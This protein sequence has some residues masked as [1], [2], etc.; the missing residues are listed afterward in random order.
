MNMDS[1]NSVS[2]LLRLK[3]QRWM[4]VLM[5]TITIKANVPHEDAH[6]LKERI[7]MDIERYGD[8]KVISVIS[9]R[10]MPEQMKMKGVTN[11]H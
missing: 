1:E 5:L 10:Q 8:C 3:R 6:G 2:V 4:E 9:D 11:E 7:A